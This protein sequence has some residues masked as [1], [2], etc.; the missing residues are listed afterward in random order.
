[1]YVIKVNISDFCLPSASLVKYKTNLNYTPKYW[2]ID[3]FS[4]FLGIADLYNGT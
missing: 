2:N 4:I 1:M 3:S